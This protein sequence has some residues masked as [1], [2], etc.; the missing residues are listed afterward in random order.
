VDATA[1]MVL[2]VQA[3]RCGAVC[4]VRARGCRGHYAPGRRA[5][6]DERR[7]PQDRM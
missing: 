2:N 6:K 3:R 4:C 7:L 5:V 1:L